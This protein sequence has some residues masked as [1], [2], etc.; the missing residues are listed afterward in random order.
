[1]SELN[2]IIDEIMHEVENPTVA[3]ESIVKTSSDNEAIFVT[4]TGLSMH[5]LSEYLKGITD[6]YNGVTYADMSAFWES[7][8]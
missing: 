7:L 6:E 1:M 3:K 4:D 2:K 5:K 8:K